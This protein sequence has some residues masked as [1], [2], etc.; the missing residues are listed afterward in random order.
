MSPILVTLTSRTDSDFERSN[1]RFKQ[2]K[3]DDV[4]LNSNDL[5]RFERA[6]EKFYGFRQT[7]CRLC[8]AL[9]KIPK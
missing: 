7:E 3:Q 1:I 2:N 6:K 8:H 5:D 9:I 4:D